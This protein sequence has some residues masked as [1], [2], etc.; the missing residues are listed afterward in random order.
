MQTIFQLCVFFSTF[1]RFL[2]GLQGQDW[3]K[4]TN[5]SYNA[6]AYIRVITSFRVVFSFIRRNSTLIFL[7][8]A[9]MSSESFLISS[10]DVFFYSYD[11][12]SLLGLSAIFIMLKSFQMEF[13]LQSYKDILYVML[14][15]CDFALHVRALKIRLLNIDRL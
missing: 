8:F 4:V 14:E 2:Q 7:F 6:H 13:L 3:E 5:R 10:H 12:M 1:G 15:M 11:F 9:N